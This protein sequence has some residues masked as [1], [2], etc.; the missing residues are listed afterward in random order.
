MAQT[1]MLFGILLQ[2]GY[3][4]MATWT[5]YLMNTLYLEYVNRQ[6]RSKALSTQPVHPQD[7]C[8][9]LFDTSHVISIM[10]LFIYFKSMLG[11]LSRHSKV[12][13]G[14]INC[15]Q[16]VWSCACPPH[17][18][19]QWSCFKGAVVRV[20]SAA[21]SELK[22]TRL[23]SCHLPHLHNELKGLPSSVQCSGQVL[24]ALA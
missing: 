16:P 4:L 22:H 13:A 8:A 7:K 10:H 11:K 6:E 24:T 9:L 3:A 14:A 19:C 23:P 2:L 17:V 12:H 15:L 5:A 21:C 18:Q 1:G 20:A